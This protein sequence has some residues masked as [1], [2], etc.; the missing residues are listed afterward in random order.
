MKAALFAVFLISFVATSLVG[1][2][3]VRTD[4]LSGPGVNVQAGVTFVLGSFANIT[5][6]QDQRFQSS[7]TFPDSHTVAFD[8]VSFS[9]QKYPASY[10][11]INLQISIWQP[12]ATS[13]TLIRWTPTLASGTIVWFNVSGLGTASYAIDLG[14]Q[15]ISAQLGPSVAFSWSSFPM[16][17]DM[18][19]TVAGSQNG[20]GGVN[21]QCNQQYFF[22][23]VRIS[24]SATIGVAVQAQLLSWYVNGVSS[25]T[26][27]TFSAT[28]PVLE[29]NGT[30]TIALVYAPAGV[31]VYTKTMPLDASLNLAIY[32]FVFTVITIIV[33]TRQ[34]NKFTEWRTRKIR[35]IT[36][37]I[38][39]SFQRVRIGNAVVVRGKLL[40]NS[41]LANYTITE[42][43]PRK[44]S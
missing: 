5:F 19:I 7:I 10:P 21:L 26:G 41:E 12:T 32:V 4:D 15:S 8:G 13:G 6:A 27:F 42:R 18:A 38:P 34:R 40:R 29:L 33:T 24:C 25:G 36:D 23:S 14:S 43:V 30:A 16:S 1:A 31:V 3:V 28:V 22:L 44:R 11:S 35:P 9:V 37:F 2:Y 39:G 20:I 17:S